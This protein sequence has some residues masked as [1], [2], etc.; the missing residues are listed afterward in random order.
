V[1]GQPLNPPTTAPW[2]IGQHT[3]EVLE[4]VLGYSA[5]RI[6]NLRAAGVI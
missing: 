4:K 3:L 1:D 6:Q 5:G 2:Q